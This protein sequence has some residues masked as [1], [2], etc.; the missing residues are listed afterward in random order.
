MTLIIQKW[1]N[2]TVVNIIQNRMTLIIQN[3][4]NVTVVNIIQ[5]RMTL[6]IQ[7]W[8]NVT[9]VNIIQTET[10]AGNTPMVTL[11]SRQGFSQSSASMAYAMGLRSLKC[12]S[13]RHPFHIFNSRFQ[14]APRMIIYDN[15]CKLHIYALNREPH[16]FKTPGFWWTDFTSRDMWAV[17]KGTLS[18]RTRIGESRPS[19]PK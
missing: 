14:Q 15:A 5:N 10:H 16:F 7:N 19:T 17:R 2:V 3:W 8:M 1:R 18:T 6:I 12:E 13:P 9:V 4:M 11:P